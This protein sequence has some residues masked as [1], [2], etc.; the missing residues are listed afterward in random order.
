[1]HCMTV[2]NMRTGYLDICRR[3]VEQGSRVAPRGIVTH[4]LTDVIIE[5][6]NPRDCLPV[7][8]GRKLNS[9]IAAAEAL[10]LIG[11][12][13]TPQLLSDI[14]PNF[15]QF[16]DGDRFWA[17]YGDRV[18]FTPEPEAMLSG[19]LASLHQ[20]S[21]VVRKLTADPDSRQAVMT[22][23][24]PAKDNEQGKHD[25][26]CTTSLIFTIRSGLLSLHTTMRSN[27][28]FWG[29]AYDAFQFTQ[30]QL[31]V[32]GALGVQAGPYFHHAISLHAY[33]RDFEA[34]GKMYYPK[35][36]SPLTESPDGVRGSNPELHGTWRDR[37]EAAQYMLSGV[38]ITSQHPFW[39]ESLG[40]Y[41]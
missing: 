15:D 11:G 26:P 1:M 23:W 27:D 22:L 32:A 12:V 40:Q 38:G 39:G 6:K 31:T 20:A 37:E 29:L 25:Y 36:A 17:A 5:V 21:A 34:I 3:V 19:P 13:S 18:R 10:Q 41:V 2:P 30:L 14:T 28:V 33:E 7:G 9:A 24:Q 16:K 4:E 35:T 8:V